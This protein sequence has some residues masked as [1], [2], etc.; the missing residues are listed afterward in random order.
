MVSYTNRDI[1]DYQQ[2]TGTGYVLSD[3]DLMNGVTLGKGGSV[4]GTLTN[5]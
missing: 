5:H 1:S 2:G 4:V 3:S